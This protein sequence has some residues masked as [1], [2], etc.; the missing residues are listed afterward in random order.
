MHALS[1]QLCAGSAPVRERFFD[2]F[3]QIKNIFNLSDF[4]YRNMSRAEKIELDL[5]YCS[6]CN[7]FDRLIKIYDVEAY[8]HIEGFFILISSNIK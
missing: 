4:I 7:Q 5:G 6:Q 1:S 3:D 2:L 8:A